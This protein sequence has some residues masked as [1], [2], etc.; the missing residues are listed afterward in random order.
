MNLANNATDDSNGLHASCFYEH[1]L[2]ENVTALEKKFSAFFED[3]GM[4][5]LNVA[6][7]LREK[8]KPDRSKLQLELNRRNSIKS[9]FSSLMC[10]RFSKL[11]ML[12]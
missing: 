7:Y 12:K 4:K 1:T 5:E 8:N 11:S 9:S 10:R 3:T 2:P 6:N